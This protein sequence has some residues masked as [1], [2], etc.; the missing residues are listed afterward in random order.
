MDTRSAYLMIFGAPVAALVSAVCLNIC[1]QSRAVA[2][3]ARH[4]Q[5][6]ADTAR[7]W[8][9]DELNRKLSAHEAALQ[10]S[11]DYQH[12]LEAAW[13]GPSEA[14]WKNADL[15]IGGMLQQ[16][17]RVCSPAGT[18]VRVRVDSFTEFEV[19]LDLPKPSENRQI[20]EIGLCL[21]LHGAPYVRSIR[22]SAAGSVL[23]ELDGA[24]ID[25]ISDWAAASVADCEKLLS[26]AA[27]GR[28]PT[29]EEGDSGSRGWAAQFAAKVR[30]IAGAAEDADSTDGGNLLGQ[31]RRAFNQ[32]LDQRNQQL[33]AILES[34][35]RAANVS[36][37][38]SPADLQ[39]KLTSL[40][41][42][43]TMLVSL[44]D[45]FLNEEKEYERFLRQAQLDPLLVSIE[46]RGMADRQAPRR[47]ALQQMFQAV[48]QR[49]RSATTFL[50]EMQRTWGSW[51][52][53]GSMIQFSSPD[54]QTAYRQASTQLQ[55]ATEQLNSA[56]RAL[57]AAG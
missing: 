10:H 37:V 47:P 23:A 8:Q 32:V 25:S 54:A 3:R 35:D 17:G 44:R 2:I 48:A 45:F 33:K 40:N 46:I 52:T 20:A 27:S 39:A 42:N 21:L 9:A 28:K 49:Q 14:A 16:V 31:S 34:Q 4:G 29:N 53:E 36:D 6:A 24:A 5:E 18:V 55:Q 41:Q 51:T 57:G 15:T 11:R 1:Y 7:R 13:G 50:N 22:F 43:E 19:S 12:Q 56:M 38:Y 30:Q 26:L